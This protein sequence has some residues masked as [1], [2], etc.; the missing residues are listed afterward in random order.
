MSKLITK[1]LKA[2]NP[3]MS[4]SC[5]Q[6]LQVTHDPS[7]EQNWAKLLLS[8]KVWRRGPLVPNFCKFFLGGSII[9]NK[10]RTPGFLRYKLTSL[11]FEKW[12]FNFLKQ[13]SH[14]ACIADLLFF[15]LS[16]ESPAQGRGSEN[17]HKQTR[18]SQEELLWP[19]AID[20]VSCLWLIF[21]LPSLEL[22]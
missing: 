9:T 19:Q 11:K 8:V 3:N 5:V 7:R 22:V 18:S 16:D 2:F 1:G 15:P 12:I 10:V 20:K 6:M 17:A 14:I 21:I 4:Y 13:E